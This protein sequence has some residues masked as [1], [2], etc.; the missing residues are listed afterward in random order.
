MTARSP[1]FECGAS[2]SFATR[3]NIQL[4]YYT[5]F[6]NFATTNLKIDSQSF[7]VMNNLIINT[8]LDLTFLATRR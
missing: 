7:V 6:T 2:T 1:H 3:P 5:L 8:Y 4:H